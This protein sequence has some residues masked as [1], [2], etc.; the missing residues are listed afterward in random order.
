MRRVIEIIGT[1]KRVSKQNEAYLVTYVL[2]DDG[3]EASVYGSDVAIG[4]EL[5]IFYHFGKIKGRKRQH[6]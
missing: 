6:T 5:E 4:D 2:V 1:E 3:T